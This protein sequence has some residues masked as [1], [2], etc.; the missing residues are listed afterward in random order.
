MPKIV[1]ID[2]VTGAPIVEEVKPFTDEISPPT[3]T[4]ATDT[5]GFQ[6][7]EIPAA[8]PPTFP[9]KDAIPSLEP[10]K[11]PV[12]MENKI[13]E[14]K[15]FNKKLASFPVVEG[16]DDAPQTL[17]T[18]QRIAIVLKNKGMDSQQQDQALKEIAAI[19]FE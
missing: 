13:D 19:L 16:K 3:S 4:E 6:V 18:L 2:P 10:E 17:S 5:G 1:G 7:K 8:L 15:A 9:P 14:A 11:K 12:G